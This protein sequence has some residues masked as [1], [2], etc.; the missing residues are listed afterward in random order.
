MELF[1]SFNTV[2]ESLGMLVPLTLNIRIGCAIGTFVVWLGLFILQGV[3]LFTMAKKVS[4][5]HK[6]L[7]FIPFANLFYIGKMVGTCRVF[8]QPVKR[9]GL[10]AMLAQIFATLVFIVYIGLKTY[11]VLVEGAPKY[12]QFGAPYWENLEGFSAV[13]EKIF[14]VCM[15]LLPIVEL[16]YT[17]FLSVLCFGLYKKYAPNNYFILG[18]QIGRASC[19]ERV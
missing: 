15:Y 16:V 2:L 14:I 7:V 3:G 11:L 6:W 10:Y 19:R 1:Q 5:K 13:A 18:M 9:A 17:L 4:K 8:G 12:D